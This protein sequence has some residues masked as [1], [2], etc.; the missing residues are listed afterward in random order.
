MGLTF[1][2]VENGGE[3]PVHKI[4]ELIRSVRISIETHLAVCHCIPGKDE[5][6]KQEL[7]NFIIT[8]SEIRY[9]IIAIRFLIRFLAQ[10]CT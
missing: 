3:Y 6:R 7:L 5:R 10:K 9:G 8:I 4:V 2:G 1:L